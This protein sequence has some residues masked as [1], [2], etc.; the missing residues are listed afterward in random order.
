MFPSAPPGVI[1]YIAG[2]SEERLIE[3]PLVVS[4]RHAG[5]G[6]ADETPY[7]RDS[8]GQL[9]ARPA[10]RPRHR[11]GRPQPHTVHPYRQRRS[12]ADMLCQVCGRKPPS[13]D[14]PHLFLMRDRGGPVR[15]G[16][17]TASPPVCVPC[18]VISVQLCPEIRGVHV[19][20]WVVQAPAWGVAGLV[21]DAGTLRPVS[22]KLVR[23]EYDGPLAP[24][25]V[26][27]RQVVQLFGVRPTELETEA[28]AFGL[29]RLEEEFKRV[30]AMVGAGR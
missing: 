17:L 7:D 23:A 4:R 1:P 10:L 27:Q 13:P 9:W 20:A 16:E 30:A 2:W 22:D 28:A 24:W 19:C 18:A 29:D 26:A 21:Y 5:L 8:F 3:A 12:M 11:R 15:D 6:Y 25:T 14:G